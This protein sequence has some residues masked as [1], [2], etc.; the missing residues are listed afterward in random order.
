VAWGVLCL[1]R[2]NGPASEAAQSARD[3]GRRARC[4]PVELRVYADDL[5]A[6]INRTEHGARRGENKPERAPEPPPSRLCGGGVSACRAG[7]LPKC[8]H[9]VRFH[10]IC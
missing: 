5:K 10:T 4:G 6:K 7:T 9:S 3:V 1:M 8:C 2:T